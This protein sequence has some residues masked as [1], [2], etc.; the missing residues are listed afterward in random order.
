MQGCGLCW[1]PLSPQNP[2]FSPHPRDG[3]TPEPH[4][5]DGPAVGASA[6]GTEPACDEGGA[7]PLTGLV[8]GSRVGGLSNSKYETGMCFCRSDS[9]FADIH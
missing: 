3:F 5:E 8:H 9:R 7:N 1:S 6:C 4:G 2:R